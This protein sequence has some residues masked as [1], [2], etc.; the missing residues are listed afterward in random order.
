MSFLVQLV[1]LSHLEDLFLDKCFIDDESLKAVASLPR[2]HSLYISFCMDRLNFLS[3]ES[4]AELLQSQS[5]LNWGLFQNH[6]GMF[7]KDMALNACLLDLRASWDAKSHTGHG[8]TREYFSASDFTFILR[9]R[10]VWYNWCCVTILLASYRAN[11]DSEIRDSILL[12]VGE[13]AENTVPISVGNGYEPLPIEVSKSSSITAS[14]QRWDWRLCSD[15]I[16]IVITVFRC[17]N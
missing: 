16:I 2:L 5:L 6:R 10:R 11:R 1:R 13:I 3:N 14:S 8:F 4:I 17:F 12:L 15:L 9:N 7:P